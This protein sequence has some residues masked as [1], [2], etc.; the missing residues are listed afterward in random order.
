[1]KTLMRMALIALVVLPAAASAQPNGYFF[2][3][4]WM[5]DPALGAL[6][7]PNRILLP[8]GLATAPSLLFAG[9]VNT[10]LYMSSGVIR[11]AYGGVLATSFYSGSIG[12]HS[13]G[14]GITFNETILGRAAANT[15]YQK[16]GANPQAFW[17]A[18]TDDGAGNYERATLAWAANQFSIA[19]GAGGTGA[20]RSLEFSGW[21]SVL[22]NATPVPG[23]DA[24]RNLGGPANK[25]KDFF[26]AQSVQGSR[27]K[28]LTDA[29]AAVAIE[30]VAVP[31]NGYVGMLTSFTA[32]S[33]D[34]T[35]RL[36]TTGLV[37]WA[38]AD[39]AGTPT[40]GAPVVVGLSTAYKRANTLVCTFTNVV[41][42]TNCDLSVTCTDN[43]AGVQTME[44]E[45]FIVSMPKPN[46]YTP[47]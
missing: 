40:C 16:N 34:G 13:A 46:T 30:R 25:W 7:A 20:T 14:A 4:H 1:M 5:Y 42:T 31:T 32:N 39:T 26:V 22:F 33:T 11:L 24:A 29:A 10:G 44:I 17:I 18:N 3:P 21:G 28:A 9:S 12:L 43:L 8:D 2:P 15:L 23:N 38:G 27:S 19:G 37:S 35:N 36:T 47:Q 41:S 45:H 6:V